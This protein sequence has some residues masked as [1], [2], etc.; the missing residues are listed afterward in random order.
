M[1]DRARVCV[2]GLVV[3]RWSREVFEG[4]RAG[5][6]T[7]A[8]CTTAVW[9]GF[10]GAMANV[11]AFKHWFAEHDDLVRPVTSV[12]DV[13]AAAR[14]GRVG[15]VLGWQNLSP[16]ADDLRRLVLFRDLGL[17]IAQLAYNTQSAFGCGCYEQRDTGLSGYGHEA[18]DELNRLGVAIDLSH[19][20]VATA[21]DAI[22]ASRAPVA[23]SHVCPAALKPHPRNRTDEEL[24]LVAERGG[25]V[26][27]TPF[28]WFLRA[29]TLEAFVDALEHVV[30]VAGEEH[31]GVGTDF[32]EGHG[33]AFVEWILRDKGTGRLVTDTPLAD[34]RVAMPDGLRRLAEWQAIPHA[35]E[36][37]GWPEQRIE[38]VVGRNWLRFLGDA[39]QAH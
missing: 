8:N 36:R 4:M 20:G 34:L 21:R 3:S 5:G 19:V 13:H 26:G 7:A 38:R 37:R 33:D 24:R 15:I 6:I 32:T 12:E 30:D 27:V 23:F 31:V 16:V 25:I 11:A 35:L 28:P 14:E 2:D 18:V 22:L 39:W 1:A 10:D 9:E 29:P 17:R